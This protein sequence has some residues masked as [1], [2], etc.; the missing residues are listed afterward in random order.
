M[1]IQ[2]YIHNVD[3]TQSNKNINNVNVQHIHLKFHQKLTNTLPLYIKQTRS[4][5]HS[6]T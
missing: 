5:N 2:Y 6:K 4:Q 3:I 1:F